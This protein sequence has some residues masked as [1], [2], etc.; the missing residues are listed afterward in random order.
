MVVG[1]EIKTTRYPALTHLGNPA[2]IEAAAAQATASSFV[3]RR[4]M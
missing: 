2:H 3:A 4:S 1:V